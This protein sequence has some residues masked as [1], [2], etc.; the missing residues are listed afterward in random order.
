MTRRQRDNPLRP[1]RGTD[2]QVFS[3]FGIAGLADSRRWRFRP[4]D[5]CVEAAIGAPF[6]PDFPGEIPEYPR[7]KDHSRNE[8]Y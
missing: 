1:P 4:I 6:G 3:F 5:P 7:D 2:K 8:R